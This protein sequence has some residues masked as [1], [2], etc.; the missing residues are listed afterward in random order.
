MVVAVRAD[1]MKPRWTGTWVLDGENVGGNR[2]TAAK[3]EAPVV[4]GD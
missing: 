4:T 2:Q 1:D 3:L